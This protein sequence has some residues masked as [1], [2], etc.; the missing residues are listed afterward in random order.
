M[1]HLGDRIAALVDG[2]LDHESRDRALAHIATCD[3]CRAEVDAERRLKARIRSL[4]EPELTA[5]LRL[6]LLSLAASSTGNAAPTFAVGRS[7]LDLSRGHPRLLVAAAAVVVVFTLTTAFAVGGSADGAGTPVS[8]A[9]DQ[10]AVEHAVLVGEVPLADSY[11]GSGVL[12][13]AYPSL[14][15]ATAPETR[16]LLPLDSPPAALDVQP[17]SAAEP[18]ASASPTTGTPAGSASLPR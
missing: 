7:G 11:A 9:V 12:S 6:R 10:Y 1:S 17:I 4:S 8:P 3:T 16:Q 15:A 13:T 18:E 2:E 14:L 5:D